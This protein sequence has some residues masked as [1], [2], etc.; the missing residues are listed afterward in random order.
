MKWIKQIN[1]IS[2]Q[3]P[4]KPPKLNTALSI[5]IINNQW[6]IKNYYRLHSA[7]HLK[8][9]NSKLNSTQLVFTNPCLTPDLCWVHSSQ[10]VHQRIIKDQSEVCY[11]IK[12]HSWCIRLKC[13]LVL[14]NADKNRKQQY[15]TLVI[16][17]ASRIQHSFPLSQYLLDLASVQSKDIQNTWC[18]LVW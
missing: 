8:C 13:F 5:N 16:S 14:K 12:H 3:W 7:C 9:T 6:S 10:T 18:T 1:L 2:T 17:N 15:C 11:T 4:S